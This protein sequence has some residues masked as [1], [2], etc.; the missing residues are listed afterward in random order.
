MIADW[1]TMYSAPRTQPPPDDPGGGGVPPQGP[2]IL[3]CDQ[4]DDMAVVRWSSSLGG[5]R[6]G[7]YAW[8]DG[9]GRAAF[10]RDPPQPGDEDG[11][12]WDNLPAGYRKF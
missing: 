7:A 12:R 4:W 8:R 1:K 6:G 9:T 11:L 2:E 3:V 10:T 5:G